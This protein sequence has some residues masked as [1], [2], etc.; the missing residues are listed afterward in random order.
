VLT[1]T[2]GWDHRL[3][4]ASW[5][6]CLG[7]IG[8]QTA[9]AGSPPGDTLVIGPSAASRDVLGPWPDVEEIWRSIGL[10][11]R[12]GAFVAAGV[13]G[14]V[15]GHAQ[16]QWEAKEYAAEH[17]AF[18]VPSIPRPAQIPILKTSLPADLPSFSPTFLL[19]QSVP[20]DLLFS[21]VTVRPGDTLSLIACQYATTVAALQTLNHLGSS[22]TIKV[23]QQLM[24]PSLLG[25][26][27][28]ACG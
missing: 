20:S 3:A 13:L 17:P 22:A 27:T 5:D 18:S 12:V 24:V 8:Q 9:P 1:E 11:T 28:A 25:S 23:G 2:L 4:A 26:P 19:P 21:T 15:L 14:L 16:A 6:D 10:A 7:R